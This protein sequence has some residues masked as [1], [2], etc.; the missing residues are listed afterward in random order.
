MTFEV[1]VDFDATNW[2][3]TPDFSEAYD[4]ISDDV[5][6]NGIVGLTWF[7]GEQPEE[8]NAPAAT[9]T[10]NLRM[11]LCQKYSPFTTDADLVGK[12]RP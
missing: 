11:G 3:A 12:I 10:V 1:C 6:I 2:A 9:L 8:G 5:D 4:N 7:R